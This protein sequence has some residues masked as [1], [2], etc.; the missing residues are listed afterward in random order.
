MVSKDGF[1]LQHRRFSQRP[2]LA[3]GISFPDLV[4]AYSLGSYAVSIR[5]DL[6]L[7]GPPEPTNASCDRRPGRALVVGGDYAAHATDSR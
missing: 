5:G 6:W 4:T 1:R 7:C 3:V 2:P